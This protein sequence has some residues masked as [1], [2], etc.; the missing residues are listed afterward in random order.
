M[1]L[2]G[3]GFGTLYEYF[4]G[5]VGLGL[6]SKPVE[7]LAAFFVD[8]TL[9]EVAVVA[10]TLV[11]GLVFGVIDLG[12]KVSDPLFHAGKQLGA[13]TAK[14]SD[15]FH[16]SA[17]LIDVVVQF[18]AIGGFSIFGDVLAPDGDISDFVVRAY[19]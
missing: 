6:L 1:R 3:G 11:G 9:D 5:C 17:G 14:A 8:C 4:S 18:A 15:V 16:G 10:G 2:V 7:E 19:E 12:L 13:Y